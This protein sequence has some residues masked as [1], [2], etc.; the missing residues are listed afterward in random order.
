M[1]NSPI[2]P[3]KLPSVQRGNLPDVFAP[4]LSDTNKGSFGTLGILGGGPGMS[5]A[6]ILAARA[7]LRLGAGKV[8]VG[9][10]DSECPMACDPIQP[11]LMLRTASALLDHS[12]MVTTWAAGCGIGD[13]WASAERLQR[14]FSIRGQ[15]PM[16]LDADG[17]NLLARGAI[18]ADWGSAPVVLTPHPAEAGRLLGTS[19]A[20]VQADRVRAARE[21]AARYGA[22]VVL[23]GTG[24]IVC[25]PEG[26]CTIN[27]TGNAGLATAGTGDVLTGMVAS[28]I[29][30]S[31]PIS[32]AVRGAVWLHGAAADALAAEG[33]GPIGLTA[34]E[35][36]DAAR[37][38]R[39]Q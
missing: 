32:Q 29:A 37:R 6:A 30:Q 35:V 27:P 21:L 31:L 38:L 28:L 7:A 5:G 11:E 24:T 39:N 2:A 9:F 4:R 22:W 36:I 26:D 18:R 10:A 8:F 3:D 25:D 33:V 34:G 1:P 14:L 12:K 16:V 13:V 20:A 19:A 15:A 23:K 17:L